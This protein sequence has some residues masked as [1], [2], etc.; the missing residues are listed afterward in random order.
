MNTGCIYARAIDTIYRKNKLSVGQ[1][2]SLHY[3]THTNIMSIINDKMI[4]QVHNTMTENSRKKSSAG[5][6]MRTH[7]LLT[8]V[9]LSGNHLP[10]RY[11]D[12]SLHKAITLGIFLLLGLPKIMLGYKKIP[13]TKLIL[14]VDSD[15]A[16]LNRDH[17]YLFRP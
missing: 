3:T 8:H 10:Y 14:G 13:I 16:S 4:A 6:R 1:Y 7:D 17:F 15:E 2:S 11:L 5:P 9:F 12:F